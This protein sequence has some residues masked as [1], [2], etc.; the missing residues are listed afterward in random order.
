MDSQNKNR[1]EIYRKDRSAENLFEIMNKALI[2]TEKEFIEGFD[3]PIHPVIFIVGAQRSGTTLLMQLMTQYFAL[4]YPNNFIARYWDVPFVGAMLYKS[5]SKDIVVEKPNLNS[6]LGY[7]QGIE[8]PHEFGYF[9]R[10]WL[11]WESWE[12]KND[13]QMD[14]TVFKKQLAAWESI[15]NTPIIFKNLIQVDFN[16]LTIK[17]ILPNAVFIFL[18]RDLVYNVQSTYQSRL[19]L[20]G[21][22][23]EWFG[24]KPP[25]FHEYQ[26]LPVL[27][28][29]ACQ[30][31]D[32][33]HAIREQLDKGGDC[34]AVTVSY[35]NLILNPKA[36]LDRIGKKLHLELKDNVDCF[37]AEVT[38]GNSVKV[39]RAI[40]E[41]IEKIC[42][43]MKR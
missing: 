20:F 38:S 37:E 4:S 36:E 3:V 25:R 9:W 28:Q 24:V 41:K 5:L 7:T 19:R 11:P 10:K 27:E 29:I 42:K 34:D 23:R 31:I 14:Y 6:D 26:K 13:S 39:D 1:T 35:E 32:T 8:G 21:D 33:N 43:K 18:E 16:I 17:E 2:S 30:I 12:E 22:D 40:F 15:N